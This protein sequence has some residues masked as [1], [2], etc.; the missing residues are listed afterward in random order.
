MVV[1]G[2]VLTCVTVTGGW[3][4][5]GVGFPVVRITTVSLSGREVSIWVGA[6]TDAQPTCK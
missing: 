5:V 3:E 1:P 6:A 4:G 2:S